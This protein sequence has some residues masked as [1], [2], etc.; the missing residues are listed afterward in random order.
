[1]PKRTSGVSRRSFIQKA[2]RGIAAAPLA[3]L[4]AGAPPAGAPVRLGID[5]FSIR[6]QG[7]SA[8]QFLDY[9]A[10]LGVEVVHFSEPRFLGGLEESHLRKV[11]T[12]A[13]KLELSI[14][15]GLGC[16][17]PTSKRFVASDGPAEEQLIRMFGV[18]K[19]LGSPIVRAYL[20][21]W[22]DRAGGM[23]P[24]IER[25]V[26]VLRGVRSRALDLG[27]KVAMEN[28]A[29]DLQAREMKTLIEEAGRDYVG[30]CL[31]SGNPV[32]A[33]EDPHLTLETLA[34]YVLTTHARD[35]AVWEE[36]GKGIAV[37]WTAMG[38]GTVGIDRWLKRFAELCPGRPLSLEIII[39]RQPRIH[40]YLDPAFWDSFRSTPAWEFAR[41]LRLAREG[42]PRHPP[43][44]PGGAKPNS[45]EYKAFLIE[46][47][48]TALE[49]SIRS[50][51]TSLGLVK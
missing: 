19:L 49:R 48:R 31:D 34:P 51:R 17:C 33:I 15:I 40:N 28:H 3:T 25:T 24:H 11:K 27:L 8:F 9:A 10:K 50:A 13:D 42:S 2:G 7:W 29:G 46:E 35:S 5:L 37:Q 18:A 16:I 20:G 47:E 44:P 41:F 45:A 6:S 21:S 14:E 26:K 36:P 32:W 1:M 38:E 12:H 43:E 4:A 22:Q 39:T 23:E 30:S